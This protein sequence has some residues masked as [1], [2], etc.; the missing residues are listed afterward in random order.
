MKYQSR[1]SRLSL[2]AA[3][4]GICLLL[5]AAGCSSKDPVSP[6]PDQASLAYQIEQLTNKSKIPGA[7]GI[8]FSDSGI[9]DLEAAGARRVGHTAKMGKQDL[10]HVGSLTKWMTATMIATLVDQGLLSW[11][12][13]PADVLPGLAGSLDTGYANITLLDLLRHHA[14]IPADEDFDSIPTL[15]GT[16]RQ[17]RVQA[18]LMVLAMPPAVAPGTYRY[19]N[20]GYVIAASMAECVTDQ[21][22]RTLMNT[23]LFQP[24]GINAFYGWPT[25]HD[26]DE[27]WGHVLNGDHFESVEPSIESPELEFTEPAGFVSMSLEDYSKFIRLHLQAFRGEPHLLSAAAFQM[28][29]TPVDNYAC[30]VQV[31]PTEYGTLFW[32][33]GSNTFF[34]MV[35]YM[36]PEKDIGIAVGINAGDPSLF[37]PVGVATETVLEKLIVP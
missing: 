30:G 29:R 32:H 3:A 37:T 33:N 11:T 27:P 22:W 18:S 1:I 2:A 24:L 17:Q 4:G 8:L 26:A 19:A 7:A 14:G 20:V 34:Y 36:I 9:T 21:D 15:T 13:K 5:A 6:T 23:R 12:T 28:L 35:M 10:M 31:T 16:L 25:E